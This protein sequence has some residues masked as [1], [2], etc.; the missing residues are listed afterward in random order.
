MHT[1]TRIWILITN[2]VTTTSSTS[3]TTTT[4]TNTTPDNDYNN[5]KI[6]TM[7][8]ILKHT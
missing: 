1:S 2:L 4:T 8:R 5:D 3:T 6:K 7:E